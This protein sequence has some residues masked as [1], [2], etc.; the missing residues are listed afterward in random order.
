MCRLWSGGGQRAP[1]H[2]RTPRAVAPEPIP[3]GPTRPPWPRARA[4]RSA[5]PP[6]QAEPARSTGAAV[7]STSGLRA[8]PEY[9]SHSQ[10]RTGAQRWNARHDR[11]RS[12]H[13]IRPEAAP[14]SRIPQAANQPLSAPLS[15]FSPT[16]RLDPAP[17]HSTHHH[18]QADQSHSAEPSCLYASAC[19][20]PTGEGSRLA[21]TAIDARSATEESPLLAGRPAESA[22]PISR[23]LGAELLRRP[24]QA[25]ET[26]QSAWMENSGRFRNGAGRSPAVGET[27]ATSRSTVRDGG[28]R[29]GA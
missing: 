3:P 12:P 15:T 9:S 7:C 26:P 13:S 4:T 29:W 2:P 10:R 18:R 19:S 1:A 21:R 27:G 23:R 16:L 22:A 17:R 14:S 28:W 24:C 8:P 6:E 20:S 5:C 11:R 25:H